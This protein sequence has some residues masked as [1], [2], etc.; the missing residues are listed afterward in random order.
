MKKLVLVLSVMMAQFA[1]AEVPYPHQNDIPTLK[2]IYN[3]Q[4]FTLDA[5]QMIWSK[6]VNTNW[7]GL[8]EFVGKTEVAFKNYFDEVMK[9]ELQYVD[10][11]AAGRHIEFSAMVGDHYHW[12]VMS[13]KVK[14]FSE[15][16][17]FSLVVYS[18]DSKV[19][20]YS[21]TCYTK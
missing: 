21:V 5:P 10:S 12:S 17:E 4:Q 20:I 2:C 1:Q 7:P 3:S 19:G 11:K 8:N 14:S 15:I 9:F 18:P 6:D 16:Q 13:Q